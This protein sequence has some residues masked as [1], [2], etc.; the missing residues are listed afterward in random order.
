MLL[1]RDPDWASGKEPPSAFGNEEDLTLPAVRGESVRSNSS[2][3]CDVRD[4]IWV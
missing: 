4:G 1:L 2:R 3:W